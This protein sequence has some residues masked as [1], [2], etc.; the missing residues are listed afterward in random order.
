MVWTL[1][2]VA[3][4]AYLSGYLVGRV[5][6]LRLMRRW[7]QADRLGR[8]RVAMRDDDDNEHA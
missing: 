2:L 1:L 6:Q 5:D 7:A 3:A 4:C 8:L